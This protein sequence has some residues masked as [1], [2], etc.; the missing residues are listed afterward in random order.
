MVNILGDSLFLV[1]SSLKVSLDEMDAN[2]CKC[3]RLDKDVFC[4]KQVD[5]T[6]QFPKIHNPLDN[7]LALMPGTSIQC[8]WVNCLIYSCQMHK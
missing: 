1:D 8:V 4:N 6:Y 3:I 7:S 5:Y 2:F